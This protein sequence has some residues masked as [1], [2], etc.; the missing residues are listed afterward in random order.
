VIYQDLSAAYDTRNTSN[1]ALYALEYVTLWILTGRLGKTW[2]V[3][4]NLIES[5]KIHKLN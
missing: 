2:Q 1:V 5:K 3:F 4:L